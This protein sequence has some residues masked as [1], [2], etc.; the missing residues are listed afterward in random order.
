[1]QFTAEL[2]KHNSDPE[3]AQLE[4]QIKQRFVPVHLG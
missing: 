4:K 2:A 3:I 1:M